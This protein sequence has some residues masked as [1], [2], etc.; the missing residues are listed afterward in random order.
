M[1][2]YDTK[3]CGIMTAILGKIA[4]GG[5]AESG[6]HVRHISFLTGMLLKKLIGEDRALIS[7]GYIALISS[8]AALHDIGKT[9][10]PACILNKPGKLDE[11][12]RKIMQGHTLAGA[13]ILDG[14]QGFTGE[15]FVRCA[16]DI[17]LWHHERWDGSGYPHGLQGDAIP[18]AAQL[19]SVVDVYDAL[20]SQRCYKEAMPHRQAMDMLLSGRCGAF[21]PL[22]MD[23]L[24]SMDVELE[25]ALSAADGKAI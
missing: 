6:P 1:Q 9:A 19:V 3:Y 22:L 10:V 11:E 21:N 25:A 12:E 23:C 13:E 20:T 2:S 5:N 16:R 14:L 17:C 7:E 4:E 18:F 24:C 15:P 8:A